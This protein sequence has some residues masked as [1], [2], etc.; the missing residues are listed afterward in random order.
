VKRQ[1]RRAAVRSAKIKRSFKGGIPEATIHEYRHVTADAPGVLGVE[2]FLARTSAVARTIA[3]GEEGSEVASHPILLTLYRLVDFFHDGAV[4]GALA[5][6]RS[7][8]P[9]E[10][11]GASE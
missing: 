3:C 11:T 4:F 8:K 7:P 6:L 1:R 10:Q 2:S 9:I 5:F